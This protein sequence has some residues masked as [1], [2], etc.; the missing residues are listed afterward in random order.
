MTRYYLSF[1]KGLVKTKY[2]PAPEPRISVAPGILQATADDHGLSVRD[3]TSAARNRNI[4][5][6]RFDAMSR[7]RSVMTSTGHH[8]FST[9][10][11]GKMLGGRDHTTVLSGL[12]RWDAFVAEQ[13][14]V[15]A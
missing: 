4:V 2:V 14:A 6:A 7:L 11:I 15:A 1:W 5:F 13:Q 10:Q 8:R 9:S 3:L 12:R